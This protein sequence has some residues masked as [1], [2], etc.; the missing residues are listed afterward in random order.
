MPFP[1]LLLAK[2]LLGGALKFIGDHLKEIMIAGA[3]L[4]IFFAGI[5]YE[6]VKKNKE[7]VAMQEHWRELERMR[8]ASIEK[9]IEAAEKDSKEKAL[10]LERSLNQALAEGSRLQG[11]YL[12]AVKDRDKRV[13][14]LKIRLAELQKNHASEKEI[15]AIERELDSLDFGVSP[16]AL[17]TINELTL[18]LGQ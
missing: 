6:E 13:A 2:P 15:N 4:G 12:E 3:A 1:L 17:K 5:K 18:R 9:R 16:L 14:E 11:E 7:I 10:H 8:T